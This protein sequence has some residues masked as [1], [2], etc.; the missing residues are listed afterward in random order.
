MEFKND[1]Q[2]NKVWAVLAYVLFL[3]PL[4][5]APKDSKFARYHTNQGLNFFIFWL[6]LVIVL[7]IIQAIVIAVTFSSAAGLVYG[8]GGGLLAFSFIWLIFAVVLIVFF[9]QGV[10]HAVR[11]E[12]KP[13]PLI[14]KINILKV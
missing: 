2:Q 3:I 4:L 7:N 11:G 12:T 6:V 10:L 14:G 13:L 9:I 5:A 8:F 1:E